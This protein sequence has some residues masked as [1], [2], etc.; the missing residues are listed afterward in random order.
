M[1]PKHLKPVLTKE[2]NLIWFTTFHIPMTLRGKN[3][4]WEITCVDFG[5]G[6]KQPH[7]NPQAAPP[8]SEA[9]QSVP[10][11]GTIRQGTILIRGMSQVSVTLAEAND[12]NKRSH[13]WELEPNSSSTRWLFDVIWMFSKIVGFPPKSSILIGFSI[14]NHQFWCTTIFG[15]TMKN[16]LVYN[17][18]NNPT[19]MPGL[20][21]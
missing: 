3:L 13:T 4:R 20:K 18:N 11:G 10:L 19:P 17:Y 7:V 16:H 1:E 9:C 21:L 12:W 8:I 14:I 2:N 5:Q 15:K 6:K